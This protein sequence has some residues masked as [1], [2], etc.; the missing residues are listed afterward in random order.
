MDQNTHQESLSAAPRTG[1]M[2]ISQLKSHYRPDIFS[3][4]AELQKHSGS[5][6][7]RRSHPTQEPWEPEWSGVGG[8]GGEGDSFNR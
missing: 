3:A 8:W 2:L 4:S 5:C 1:G 6:T 7:S